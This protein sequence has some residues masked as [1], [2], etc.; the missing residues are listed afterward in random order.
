MV[1]FATEQQSQ[2]IGGAATADGPFPGVDGT[3]GHLTVG[4]WVLERE[5]RGLV[6]WSGVLKHPFFIY[7]A[8]AHLFG[9]GLC[10]IHNS[11][12]LKFL[13]KHDCT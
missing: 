12:F 6:G 11:R 8:A 13:P 7:A 10:M 9:V 1:L 4:G 5:R 2:R 3:W